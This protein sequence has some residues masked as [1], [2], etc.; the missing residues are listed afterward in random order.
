MKYYYL[1]VFIFIISSCNCHQEKSQKEINVQETTQAESSKVA[2]T[3][4][5]VSEIKEN[6]TKETPKGEKPKEVKEVK[7]N[8]QKENE[9]KTTTPTNE[10]K[11]VKKEE[12]KQNMPVVKSDNP[13]ETPLQKAVNNYAKLAEAY[14]AWMVESISEGSHETLEKALSAQKAARKLEPDLLRQQKD[15]NAD[16]T[17]AFNAARKKLNKTEAEFVKEM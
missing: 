14:R 4:E 17:A 3:T 11:T 6:K 16:Q 12:P 15:F 8:K 10:P 9:V 7:D 2:N 1:I 5:S 13:Q